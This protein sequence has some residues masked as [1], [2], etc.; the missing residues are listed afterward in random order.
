MKKVL[1]IANSRIPTEKAHGYQIMKTSEAFSSSSVELELILPTR[2]NKKIEIT[3][4]FNYYKIKNNFKITK[5]KCFDPRFLM[6]FPGG[7]YI[8]IQSLLFITALSSY[9]KKKDRNHII[10]TRDELLLP[11][12]HRFSDQVVWEAHNIPNNKKYYLKYWK[13]CYRIVTI[14]GG[15]KKELVKLGIP[16]KKILVAP[17]GVDLGDFEN[18]TSDKKELR[19]DLNLPLDK[20]IIMYTGHLYGWKGT[21]VLAESAKYLSNQEMIVFVGGTEKDIKEFKKENKDNRIISIIGRKPRS[22]IPKYLKAADVLVL[23]NSGR[24]DISRLYTSPLKL[25]EYMASNTS[26]VASNL[27]SIKEILNNNNSVLVKADNSKDLAGGIKKV[28]QNKDF[29]NKIA[30]QAY[31]DVQGYSWQKRADSILNFLN[32]TKL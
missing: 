16:D 28:L 6:A 11:F 27:P 20:N 10:Y 9:L 21:Q 5:I 14:S 32:Q 17:D 25:F 29:A 31:G 1:Y 24:S 18:I 3:D 12:L 2:N 30:N 13:K 26:I 19:G 7:V 8:K 15:L 23:P 22:D 4:P